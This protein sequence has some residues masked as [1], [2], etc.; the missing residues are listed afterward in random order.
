MR[1]GYTD[2]NITEFAKIIM[3]EFIGVPSTRK[4]K[5]KLNMGSD[6]AGRVQA[7]IKEL[8]MSKKNNNVKITGLKKEDDEIN[9]DQIFNSLLSKQDELED[10]LHK[11]YNQKIEIKEKKAFSISCISDCH[12][13]NPGVDYRALRDDCER[14]NATDGM[15]AILAGDL[16][17][18]WI[19]KGLQFL[20]QQQAVN[21]PT[22]IALVKW[23]FQTLNNSL[24]GYV[25]GNHDNWTKKLA[26]WDFLKDCICGESLYGSDEI[27]FT[28]HADNVNEKYK[29]RH[30]FKGKSIYNPTH[31]MER[32]L[33]FGDDIWDVAVQGHTHTGTLLRESIYKHKKRFCVLLGTYK[34]YDAFQEQIGFP[35]TL[36]NNGCMTIVYDQEGQ[37]YFFDNTTQAEKYLRYLRGE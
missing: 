18:N 4:I 3:D 16:H 34:F 22:E 31:G 37:K 7:K 25:S 10:R 13:G 5:K 17:D 27:N 1:H 30:N 9:V 29:I 32:D 11:K 21:F 26:G 28:I 14:I 23:L 8:L 6:N 24:V 20:Q 33:K 35:R 12:I 19:I 36:R 15:Y 2:I